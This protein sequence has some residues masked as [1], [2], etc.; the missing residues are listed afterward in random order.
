MSRFEIIID[1]F[2]AHSTMDGLI[3][4]MFNITVKK[5]ELTSLKAGSMESIF[6]T[7]TISCFIPVL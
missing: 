6:E 3:D 5:N 1:R 4:N 7:A 2:R